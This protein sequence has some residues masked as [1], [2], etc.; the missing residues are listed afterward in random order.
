M[1]SYKRN[2]NPPHITITVTIWCCSNSKIFNFENLHK[3]HHMLSN[4]VVKNK[5]EKLRIPSCMTVNRR[6]D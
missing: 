5:H 4:V 1:L 6:A 3:E 2:R